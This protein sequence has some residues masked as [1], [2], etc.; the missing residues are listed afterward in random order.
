MTQPALAIRI[1]CHAL[2]DRLPEE[3]FRELLEALV[4]LYEYHQAPQYLP[5]LPPPPVSVEARLSRTY[6][7]PTVEIEE[8]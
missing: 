6:V 8:E 5:A 1:L 7:R 3:A 2:V 4:S